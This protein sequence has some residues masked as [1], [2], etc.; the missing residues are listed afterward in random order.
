M[1]SFAVQKVLSLIGSH[2]FIFVLLSITHSRRWIQNSIAVIYI[3]CSVFLKEFY[4]IQS[5]I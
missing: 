4:R 1:V 2:L 5:Y 3:A